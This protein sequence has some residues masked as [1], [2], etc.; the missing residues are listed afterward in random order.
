MSV[1]AGNSQSVNHPQ[2]RPRHDLSAGQSRA[3]VVAHMSDRAAFTWRTG[4]IEREFDR[5]AL[6]R[7]DLDGELRDIKAGPM[8]RSKIIMNYV[9][10]TMSRKLISCRYDQL[11]TCDIPASRPIIH[12]RYVDGFVRGVLPT[13][14]GSLR[15][16]TSS[17]NANTM[18]VSASPKSSASPASGHSRPQELIAWTRHQRQCQR[19]HTDIVADSRFRLLLFV[20]LI[21]PSLPLIMDMAMRTIRVSPLSGRFDGNTEHNG[22]LIADQRSDAA[23]IRPTEKFAINVGLIAHCGG[24]IICHAHKRPAKY[25]PGLTKT[26]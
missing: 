11:N 7:G 6:L 1:Q 5:A 26:K 9:I 25:R 23:K 18:L 15:T 17:R 24:L 16:T 12:G 2:S 3:D 19:H 13:V 4:K 14:R 20:L 22:D 21:F 10:M 8:A